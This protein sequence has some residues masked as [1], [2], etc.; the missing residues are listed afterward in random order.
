MPP[1]WNTTRTY[2][3]LALAAALSATHANAQSAEQAPPGPPPVLVNGYASTSYGYNLNHPG[4]DANQFHVFDSR[5]DQATLDVLAF[6]VHRDAAQAGQFEFRLD[7]AAGSGI[8]PVTAA[9]GLFRDPVTGHARDFDVQQV[10]AGI[11]VPL[12]SGLRVD[13]GKFITHMGYE[14]I[15]RWDGIND[16]ASRSFLFGY[17][18]PFTD[19]GLRAGY[20]FSPHFAGTVFLLNGW[21]TVRGDRLLKTIG[22][23]AAV[24]VR[25]GFSIML[26]YIDGPEQPGHLANRR[27]VF[28]LCVTTK[29]SA[30]LSL[31]F[32]ADYGREPAIGM[33]G[34]TARWSGVAGYANVALG[35]PWS[36]AARAEV[37]D[38]PDGVRTG[39]AQRLSEF[40]LTPAYRPSSHVILRMDLRLDRSDQAVF[41]SRVM[42]DTQPVVLLNAAVVF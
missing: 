8:P 34:T 28:D 1:T 26:N 15:D 2:A 4:S 12:G 19:T 24:T 5:L 35:G 36:V 42:K 10:Y 7:A 18:V 40:T 20:T 3:L 33:G 32:N 6:S 9:T 16:N 41:T 29:M 21:D 13:A 11:I 30:R 38:D 27:N 17:A 22:A 37:F 25:D 31:G 39:F 23:Q 14:S